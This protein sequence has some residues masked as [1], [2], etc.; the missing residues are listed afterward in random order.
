M[1][2]KRGHPECVIPALARMA[3]GDTDQRG[4][5]YSHY[6]IR[7]YRSTGNLA[8]G[9][10]ARDLYAWMEQNESARLAE[11]TRS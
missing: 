2:R 1:A 10:D 3:M 11:M 8:P 4:A 6:I 7:H 5:I 9:C